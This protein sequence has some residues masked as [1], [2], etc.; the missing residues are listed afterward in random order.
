VRTKNLVQATALG[1]VLLALAACT[2]DGGS[3]GGQP[4]V[5]A[6]VEPQ[7]GAALNATTLEVQALVGARE[8]GGGGS[9]PFDRHAVQG[10]NVGAVSLVELSIDGVV[11]DRIVPSAGRAQ[12]LADLKAD[13][14]GLADG[15]HTLTVSAFQN[16]GR[17]RAGVATATFTIDRTLPAAVRNPVEEAATPEPFQAL[18]VDPPA[19]GGADI[20]GELDLGHRSDGIDPTRERIVFAIGPRVTAIEPGAL[21]RPVT[22]EDRG[23]GT[24]RF[25]LRGAGSPAPGERFQLRIGDDFGAVDLRT[26]ELLAGL[27]PALDSARQAEATIGAAG[28]SVETT[29]ADGV[30]IRLDVP[31]GAL[32]RDTTIRAIP[33]LFGSARPDAR[34]ALDDGVRFEPEGLRFAI[35]AT[36]TLDFSGAP[37][38][39]VTPNASI[40]LVTSPLTILPLAG[41]TDVAG[42]TLTAQIRHFSEYEGG[43]GDPAAMDAGDWAEEGTEGGEPLSVD[44]IESL[45]ALAAEQQQV[46]CTAGCIDVGALAERVGE[47]IE[48]TVLRDCALDIG[49]P[50][51]AALRKYLAL[52]ALAQQFGASVPS[53]RNCE[54][55]ILSA[56]IDREGPP[57]VADPS[58]PNL[59]RLARRVETAQQLGFDDLALRAAQFVDQ[60]LTA[61][62][63]RL[64]GDVEAADGTVNE[65]AVNEAAKDRLEDAL[66]FVRGDGAPVLEEVPDLDDR[67]QDA[68]DRIT[69]AAFQ[70]KVLRQHTFVQVAGARDGPA[71]DTAPPVTLQAQASGGS[72]DYRLKLD[73]PNVL[74]V[75]VV[76]S[77]GGVGP[78]G[79]GGTNDDTASAFGRYAIELTFQRDGTV[80]FEMGTPFTAG[81][82]YQVNAFT[83]VGSSF[84]ENLLGVCTFCL[85]TS[86]VTT[87]TRS[88][89]G[90][91]TLVLFLDVTAGGQPPGSLTLNAGSVS[92]RVLTVTYRR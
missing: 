36:L 56:L 65:E 89:S 57:A 27:R 87:A 22:I 47:S 60:A 88:V 39:A 23:N 37:A 67:I 4:P 50:S 30:R 54:R 1:V 29:D 69:G 85:P 49:D 91:S 77:G 7:D 32:T 24:F 58:Q 34:T 86:T 48:A 90:G 3:G 82:A 43:E 70:V 74:V 79:V 21:D 64:L 44:A 42:K 2:G 6:L 28:G 9:F 66:A 13:L 16:G 45:A 33:L 72:I 46:G 83:L 81:G 12:V 41:T 75:D 38:S 63:M 11:A 8:P 18:V 20:A 5:V 25:T 31:A 52:E 35:P 76:A 19:P 61:L 73:E 71:A 62:A 59:S 55:Q 40:F 92:G 80:T 78:D 15:P 51:D 10:R 53:I 84:G 26:G 17:R 68:I 14:T